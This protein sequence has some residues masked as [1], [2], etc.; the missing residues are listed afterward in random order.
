MVAQRSRDTTPELALRR[1]LHALGFAD[2]ILDLGNGGA[3]MRLVSS[4]K[5]FR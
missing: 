2:R 4:K 1:A 3:P 5:C